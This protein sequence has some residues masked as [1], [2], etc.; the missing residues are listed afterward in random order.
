MSVDTLIRSLN[1]DKDKIKKYIEKLYLDNNRYIENSII[2]NPLTTL[3]NYYPLPN[4]LQCDYLH[5]NEKILKKNN[6]YFYTGNPGDR[7]LFANRRLPYYGKDPI[8]FSFPIIENNN[9]HIIQSNIFYFEVKLCDKAF[10]KPWKNEC[11]SIGFGTPSTYFKGQVGWCNNS[12]GFHSDDGCFIHN[13]NSL[14]VSSPWKLNTTYGVGLKY[15]SQNKYN[16]FLTINGNIIDSDIQLETT[17]YL[18]PMIGFD[19]SVPIKINWGEESFMFDIKKHINYNNILS[20]KNSFF[21][22]PECELYKIKPCNNQKYYIFKSNIKNIKI[23][24]FFSALKNNSSSV[25]NIQNKED[26][27]NNNYEEDNNNN[28]EE[29]TNESNNN[30]QENNNEYNESNNNY[31]GDNNHK[32][33]NENNEIIIENPKQEIMTDNINTSQPNINQSSLN[34]NLNLGL[35]YNSPTTIPSNSLDY[36]YISNLIQHQIPVPPTQFQMN[37]MTLGIHTLPPLFH[38]NFYTPIPYYYFPI[39]FNTLPWHYHQS[40]PVLNPNQPSFQP[41]PV[42]NPNQPS[43]QPS[44]VLNPN[45]PP[46]YPSSV[47]NPN[48]PPFQPSSVLN[49]NQQTMTPQINVSTNQQQTLQPPI[50]PSNLFNEN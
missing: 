9:T 17:E 38:N 2:P 45:Q 11:L 21:K 39:N 34:N 44:P 29:E 36:Q 47:L 43:F 30:Y 28:Y 40:S 50:L 20:H 41:S 16:I 3:F 14:I 32:Y 31:E 5:A 18:I 23:N 33:D 22:N 12:W 15:I 42:L 35:N 4:N 10:R 25:I 48:Q 6:Y 19:L 37:H 46:F 24:E 49:P 27:Y 1:N 26:K 7:I 8:P 13:N